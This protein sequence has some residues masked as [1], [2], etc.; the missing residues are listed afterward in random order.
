M[1]PHCARICAFRGILQG[2]LGIAFMHLEPFYRGI[3]GKAFM[4]LG[5]LQGILGKDGTTNEV[6]AAAAFWNAFSSANLEHGGTRAEPHLLQVRLEFSVTSENPTMAGV[7][8]HHPL[9]L[10][11][12]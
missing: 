2:I 10:Q 8:N 5:I 12:V 9:N 1:L 3:L 7:S 11:G 4:H 6:N